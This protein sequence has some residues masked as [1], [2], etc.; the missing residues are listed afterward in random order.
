MIIYKCFKSGD[1]FASDAF[2]VKE[3]D[4]G[5]ILEVD[6]K[7]VKITEGED[8]QLAGANPSAEDPEEVGGEANTVIA[9]NVEKA[10]RLQNYGNYD[11]K[12]FQAWAKQWAKA[13]VEHLEGEGRSERVEIFKKN[14]PEIAKRMA[15]NIKNYEIFVGENMDPDGTLAFLDYREDGITPYFTLLKDGLKEMKL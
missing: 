1:E 11:K 4:D 9:N 15:K 6:C 8:I 5:C 13:I 14:F 10:F 2:P 12:Q 7:M 3:T